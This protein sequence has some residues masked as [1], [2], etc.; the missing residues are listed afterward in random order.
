MAASND[1]VGDAKV[2]TF[3]PFSLEDGYWSWYFDGNNPVEIADA[4]SGLDLTGDFTIEFW[5]Y[6]PKL[7][8]TNGT[9]N[10]YFT[11]DTLDRFQVGSNTSNLFVY[12]NGGNTL[13]G[14]ASPLG[15][16]N[17]IALVRSGSGSNNVSLYRNGSRLAQGTNTTSLA[18]GSLMLGGQDRGGVTGYHGCFMYMSN[19]RILKGTALYSGTSYTVPSSP[20]TAITNTSLLT[21]QSNRFRDNSTNNMTHTT[22]YTEVQAFSPFAPSRSYSKDAVGGS[23]HLDGT[24]DWVQINANKDINVLNPTSTYTLEGWFYH[25][26]DTPGTRYIITKGGTG[27]G[28]GTSGHYVLVFLYN[29]SIYIQ[30]KI[31]AGS[32]FSIIG[33]HGYS[34]QWNH[35]A[36]GYDGTTHRMWY[37]GSSIGTNTSTPFPDTSTNGQNMF[38]GVSNNGS[39][40]PFAGYISNIRY[41][42]GTDIYGVSNASITVPTAPP[43]NVANTNFL[44]NFTNGAIIDHSMKN[45]LETEGNTRIRTDTKKYGTGSIFFDGVSD[46]MV[47]RKGRMTLNFNTEKFTLSSGV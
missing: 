27:T 3:S 40:S 45:N 47:Q 33:A 38:I 32:L 46:V 9:V 12:M 20:L 6:E 10:M 24:G 5:A 16:W 17:H 1:S 22:Y 39:T 11:I 15:Q 18:A 21:C 41:V 34:Y 30:V 29:G 4:N 31:G 44:T 8:T 28:W 14:T 2:G 42:R 19:F 37:N 26:I 35:F 36:V 13:N 43:T 23:I 7:A 25:D